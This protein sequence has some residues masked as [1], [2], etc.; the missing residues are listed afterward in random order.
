MLW[1]LEEDGTDVEY[2]GKVDIRGAMTLEALQIKLE[3]NDILEW[4]FHFWDPE[5]KHCVRKKLEQLYNIST[6]VHVIW[7]VEGDADS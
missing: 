1:T 3:T 6:E 2:F 7:I 5:N 4:P